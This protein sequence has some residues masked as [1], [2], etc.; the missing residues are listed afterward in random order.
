MEAINTAML[1][2]SCHV[3]T[4]V[5][6]SRRIIVTGAL[7]GKML[8]TSQMGLFGKNIKSEMHREGTTGPCETLAVEMNRS[9]D[10]ALTKC[11]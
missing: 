8:K 3:G 1:T 9:L 10:P 4:P 6:P 2:A 11:S 7:N 5:M